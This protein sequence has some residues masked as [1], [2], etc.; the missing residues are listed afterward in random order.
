MIERR[1]VHIA[2][3]EQGRLLEGQRAVARPLDPDQAGPAL[4]DDDVGIAGLATRLQPGM[5]RAE[6]RMAG[7]RQFG[8]RCEDAQPVVGG[9]RG[10]R[11]E[12]G[13]L[14]QVR[15]GREPLH[16]LI[17]DPAG[18]VDHGHRVAAMRL[19]REDIDLREAPSH[20]R[21]LPRER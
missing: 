10:G 20:D 1:V 2:V 12:V 3:P 16:R 14:G 21:S 7:E 5:A 18:V 15:P 8:R 19:G 6:G 4:L 13:R 11:Q 17:V 9:R